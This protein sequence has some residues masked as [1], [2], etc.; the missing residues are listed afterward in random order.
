MAN[1][2]S[3]SPVPPPHDAWRASAFDL[4]CECCLL[5]LRAQWNYHVK[6]MHQLI[7]KLPCSCFAGL[8][9]LTMF[10]TTSQRRVCHNMAIK[11][12]YTSSIQAQRMLMDFIPCAC[13]TFAQ[14]LVVPGT[15]CTYFDTVQSLWSVRFGSSLDFTTSRKMECFIGELNSLGRVLR[16][17]V[18]RCSSYIV[19]K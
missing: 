3:K 19:W 16:I 5:N 10:M 11:S 1:S 12:P 14:S 7:I 6:R 18:H 8:L 4:H 2:M 13:H 17:V 9:V 15:Y